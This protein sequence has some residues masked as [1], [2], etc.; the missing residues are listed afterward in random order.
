M[1]TARQCATSG[2]LIDPDVRFGVEQRLERTD[3]V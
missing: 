3:D 1:S 2:R